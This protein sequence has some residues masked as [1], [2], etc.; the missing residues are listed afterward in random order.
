MKSK[1][2]FLTRG[3][4]LNTPPFIP[5]IQMVSVEAY[6][7]FS[8]KYITAVKKQNN[9]PV[10]KVRVSSLCMKFNASHNTQETYYAQQK[11]RPHRAYHCLPCRVASSS[12]QEGNPI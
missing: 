12:K 8:E 1:S 3:V 9:I 10:A 6:G 5:L 11:K 4:A 7:Y 2:R